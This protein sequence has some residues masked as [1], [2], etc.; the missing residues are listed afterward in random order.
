MHWSG[1]AS[2]HVHPCVAPGA[3][4][5]FR[6]ALRAHVHVCACQCV[7]LGQVWRFRCWPRQ[8]Q[9]HPSNRCYFLHTQLDFLLHGSLFTMSFPPLAR[10]AVVAI[11]KCCSRCGRRLM[12]R[13]HC[14]TEGRKIGWL[15]RVFSALHLSACRGLLHGR[16]TVTGSQTPR[17]RLIIN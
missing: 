13:A 5:H 14:A 10:S 2:A 6:A 1:L 4:V 11:S 16:F 8:Q 9:T 12:Q 7:A 15:Q 17:L 3:H